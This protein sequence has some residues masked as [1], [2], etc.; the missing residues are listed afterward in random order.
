MG[1]WLDLTQQGLTTLQEA[2]SFAWR[3]NAYCQ[4]ELW[5]ANRLARFLLPSS[6]ALALQKSL[7]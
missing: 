6:A 1:G 4:N 2:P 5:S 3:T 7:H